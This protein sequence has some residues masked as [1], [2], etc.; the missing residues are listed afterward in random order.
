MLSKCVVVAIG[1]AVLSVVCGAGA[2][3]TRSDANGTVLVDGRKTFPI[4]LAKGPPAGST[5]PAGGDATAEVVGAG[6]NFLKIG[7][8]TV[9]WT[10]AE[11]DD[12]E[13]ENRAAAAQGAYTW[14][15]LTTVS[16][17]TPG[18]SAD[19]LLEQVVTTLKNDS[20]SG[21][22]GMWKGADEPWWGGVAPSALQ[23]AYCRLTSRGE[24]SWCAGEPALDQD[25]LWVTIQAPRGTTSDLGPYAAVTDVHGAD[26]YPVT[27]ADPAP[28]LAQVGSWTSI[29][30]AATPNRAL[31]T[32]L[33]ICASG[34]VRPDGSFVL[35]TRAQERFMIYDAIINGA[36]SL[37]FYGGNNPACWNGTTDD[38]H[39]WN[40]TFWDTTLRGLVGEISAISPLAPALVAP[41][42]TTALP[43]SDPGTEVISR[44]GNAGDVWV[45]AAR[46]GAGTQPVTI[47]GLPSSATGATVYTEGR[48]VAVAGGS[49]TDDFAQWGVHVYHIVPPAPPPP[50][51]PPQIASIAPT[52]GAVQSRVTIMGTNLG[53]TTAVAFGGV[54]AGF[55][56]VSAAELSATV[57]AGAAS[58][59]VTVTTP[60]GTATSTASFTVTVES[61]PPPPP[62]PP[63]SGGGGS[64]GL[65]MPSDLRVTLTAASPSTRVGET[66]DVV[67]TVVEAGGGTSGVRL[68]ITLPPGLSLPSNPAS[69]R[70]SSCTAAAVSICELGVLEAGASVQVRFSIRADAAGE[71][72]VAASIAAAQVDANPA[73]NATSLAIDVQAPLTPPSVTKPSVTKPTVTKPAATQRADRLVGTARADTLRGLGGPDTILGLAGDD[74]LDGGSGNDTLVGGPGRDVLVGRIGNDVLSVRDGRRDRVACGPGRDRVLADRLDVVA[75]DCERVVRR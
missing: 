5:T 60:G 11:L 70:S 33:E 65:P 61:P 62:P 17:A 26:I 64:G 22:I 66:N 38:Q 56:V 49:L 6:V 55:T 10:A 16:R 46:S 74:L 8:A 45:L 50:P 73:D 35:P 2:A 42:S 72:R 21:A 59:P 30:A 31:W 53:G 40:W 28:D 69:D 29:M 75:S 32:T 15:N 39:S 23:F 9:P 44:A 51:A 67:A 58:G 37:A 20:A 41:G 34:S 43:A 4:V 71:Q 19:R 25:H 47:S 27:A 7:P 14:I 3:V 57:P 54:A 12:A 36:R 18:S 68:T 1:L 63:P 52:T 48:A 13:R 24:T